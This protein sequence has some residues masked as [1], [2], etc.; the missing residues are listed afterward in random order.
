MRR[1]DEQRHCSSSVGH[2]TDRTYTDQASVHDGGI[3]SLVR[4]NRIPEASSVVPGTLSRVA[5]LM[6]PGAK[7]AVFVGTLRCI[8]VENVYMEHDSLEP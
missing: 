3:S 1:I 2:R 7:R 4:S 5:C 6:P 8:Q